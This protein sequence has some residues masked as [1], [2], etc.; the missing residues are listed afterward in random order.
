MWC[1]CLLSFAR[2]GPGS[3]VSITS[4]DMI[5]FGTAISA[6][7]KSEQWQAALHLL[8][9]MGDTRCLDTLA[10]ICFCHLLSDILEYPVRVGPKVLYKRHVSEAVRRPRLLTK[11]SK[12]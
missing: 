7:A 6:C 4:F 1:S 8:Q 5:S 2:A 11:Q 12:I 10:R 3:E 9:W